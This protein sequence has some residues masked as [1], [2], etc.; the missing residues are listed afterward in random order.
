M[1]PSSLALLLAVV[2]SGMRKDKQPRE[3][4]AEALEGVPAGG[5]DVDEHQVRGVAG[6]RQHTRTMSCGA[7][8]GVRR[9]PTRVGVECDR[10]SQLANCG[11]GCACHGRGPRAIINECSTPGGAV[12]V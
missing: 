3:D 1:S 6:D 5:V 8:D 11:V 12:L 9:A 7:I 10:I 4:A 2:A